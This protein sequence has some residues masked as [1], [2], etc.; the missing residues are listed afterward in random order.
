[1]S[2]P[3]AGETIATDLLTAASPFEMREALRKILTA[4]GMSRRK[5]DELAGLP[6]GY[7]D[8]LLTEPPV[9]NIGPRSL[10][11]LLWAL[12]YRIAF[13]PDPAARRKVMSHHLFET[14][15][16]RKALGD[17]H[18]RNAKLLGMVRQDLKNKGSRGGKA[19]FA[20]MSLKELKRHQRK[21][22]DARWKAHRRHK[23]LAAERAECVAG[24]QIVLPSSTHGKSSST[25]D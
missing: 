1:M 9:R 10:F 11:P 3:A 15:D 18:W 5:F 4:F 14:R 16:E 23:K 20:R 17:E 22:S 13:V 7:T 19:K 25:L 24:E 12:G 6:T 8:K 2:V 21:A